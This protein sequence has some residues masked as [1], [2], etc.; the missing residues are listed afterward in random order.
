MLK[1]HLKEQWVI[2]PQ[3]NS[4]FVAAMEDVL[5][6]YQRPRDPMHPLVCMDESTKQIKETREPR[7]AE[8]GRPARVDYEYERNGTANM[9]MMFAPLEGWR[10][11]KITG[12]HT[13]VDYAHALKD[14]SGIH[15]PDVEQIVRLQ[16]NLNTHK[17]ASLYEAF[18][19]AEARRLVERF[20]WHYTT[21]HGSWLD[22][23]ESEL[24]VLATQCLDRRIPDKRT[25]ANEIAAW[26][27]PETPITPKPIGNSQ[28][29]TLASNSSACTLN[30]G[31]LHLH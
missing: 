20:E 2:P 17:P 23:A 10:H 1:P 19:P 9:F 5:D 13:A 29:T 8:P 27:P 3:E 26:E 15:F 28:P 12:R 16:D 11:V 24:G 25:L 18:P 30:S 7:P 31:P 22:M 14:L 21:K 6:V 4:A